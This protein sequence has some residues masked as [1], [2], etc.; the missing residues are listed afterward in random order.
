MLKTTEGRGE[1][2]APEARAM[3]GA[4]NLHGDARADKRHRCM[5]LVADS[6]RLRETP[7]GN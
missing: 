6:E 3:D 1:A 5:L 2:D 4:N 7:S